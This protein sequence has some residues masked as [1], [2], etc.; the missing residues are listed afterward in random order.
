[1]PSGAPGCVSSYLAR[2]AP[3]KEAK[4]K[5]YVGAAWINGHRV[6]ET[7]NPRSGNPWAT[8]PGT[9]GGGDRGS[10]MFVGPVA[11]LSSGSATISINDLARIGLVGQT[12]SF[13]TAVGNLAAHHPYWILSKSGTAGSGNITVSWSPGG[14]PI[15]APASAKIQIEDPVQSASSG[16]RANPVG[17]NVFA[18]DAA[19]ADF[20]TAYNQ[21]DVKGEIAALMPHLA[22]VF[23][24]NG[25]GVVVLNSRIFRVLH[26]YPGNGYRVW[27]RFEDLGSGGYTGELYT[28]RTTGLI[29][30]T[31]RTDLKESCAS[32]NAAGQ[33]I[34][35]SSLETLV[36]ISSAKADI[37]AA[38]A[39]APGATVGNFVFRH[40][41]FEH[42]N[43]AV[44]T[45][46]HD[47]A[48][49]SGGFISTEPAHYAG[50]LEWAIV[51]IGARNVTFDAVT[52]AHFGGSALAVGWGSNHGT[53]QNSKLYDAGGALITAGAALS[54][55]DSYH[56]NSDSGYY[57]TSVF[58]PSTP[59]FNIGFGAINR[60]LTGA[61]DCCQTFTNN[62]LYDGGIVHPAMGC[63]T[64]GGWQKYVITHNTMHDCGSSGLS[65][66]TDIAAAPGPPSFLGLVTAVKS[67]NTVY[68]P[69][70]GN[71][72]SYN[73]IY[74]CGYETTVLGAR[75]PGG[76]M[77]TDFG[78]LYFRGS[79]DGDGTNPANRLQ[80]TYN[81][82]HDASA[83]AYP[84]LKWNGHGLSLVPHGYDAVLDYQDGNNANGVV[85]R[86]NLFYNRSAAAI[87][88]PVY[89]S[90][91][92]QH[93]GSM[94]SIIANNIFASV[95]PEG[96]KIYNNYFPL[97]EVSPNYLIPE[98]ASNYT[99]AAGACASTCYVM[100]NY[101]IYSSTFS[102]SRTTGNN[103]SP[104]CTSGVCTDGGVTWTWVQKLP[105]TPYLQNY[106]NIVAW[107]VT[108]NPGGITKDYPLW[109]GYP[110][111]PQYG[112]FSKNLYSMAGNTL[113]RASG[114]FSFVQWLAEKGAQGLLQDA[115]SL[116]GA[117]KAP[118]G[119]GITP[120]F[121]SIDTGD[122]RFNAT[123]SGTGTASACGGTGAGTVS[124]A[125]GLGFVPWDYNNVGAH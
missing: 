73:E 57:G 52:M 83:A 16:D 97:L 68:Y 66:S 59:S 20:A 34:I 84:V 24:A 90:R 118:D 23:F 71:V 60:D 78:C 108:G 81:K 86:N 3:L 92:G 50:P 79:Q 61:S 8:V 45:G 48:G 42:T 21:T 69:F 43:T 120:N 63:M 47:L 91:I 104:T 103:T 80:I 85:E 75:I 116:Y 100:H 119:G 37:A 35:P 105:G 58:G 14:S 56:Y 28:N 19:Q 102:D 96:S 55:F 26:M 87:G 25:K 98:P 112:Q 121:V 65:I 15:V 109:D 6:Q 110:R 74:N 17:E 76:A 54:Y 101:N 113:Y 53:V 41:L 4:A 40:I 122:F 49:A 117:T 124:P 31:P 1:L 99:Y 22:P 111:N 123:Y 77:S 5:Y 9:A 30:Y 94:R 67:G 32:I 29:Y 95:F 93:T 62:F 82:I 10:S 44:F 2:L 70:Y 39:G 125:C 107:K 64:I 89:P 72:I 106:S 12:I 33:A 46:V 38:G 7:I 115:G 18:Y 13:D 27:N 51:T 36:K 114:G 11:R 88:A